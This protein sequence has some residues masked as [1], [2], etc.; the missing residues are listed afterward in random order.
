MGRNQRQREIN[1]VSVKGQPAMVRY[2]L[3][4][5]HSCFRT[6]K[7]APRT[8]VRA[9]V[10]RSSQRTEVCFSMA[11]CSIFVLLCRKCAP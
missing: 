2:N 11:G 9:T 7:D 10:A 8:A 3:V 1:Q 6:L 5:L 4:S